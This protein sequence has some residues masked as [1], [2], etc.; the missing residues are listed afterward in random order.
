MF[1]HKLGH[2]WGAEA[3][4][5]WLA[6]FASIGFLV[7]ISFYVPDRGTL[8]SALMAFAAVGLLPMSLAAL[9]CTLLWYAR[10][11]IR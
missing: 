5:W 2:D 8:L 3:R 1:G 9:V 11:R 10:R 6:T 4:S 7:A